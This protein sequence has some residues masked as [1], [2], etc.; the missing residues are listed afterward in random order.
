MNSSTPDLY[1]TVDSE[2]S[3]DVDDAFCVGSLPGGSFHVSVAIANPCE[4]VSIGSDTDINARKLGA[5]I[6]LRD[7]PAHRMIHASIS[8]DRA[9]LVQG[10]SRA[11]LIFDMTLDADLEVQQA[12]VRSDQINV[13]YRLSYQDIPL[14][15]SEERRVGKECVSTCRSRWSPYH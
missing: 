8:E 5:T 11:V 6:Y 15:R 13:A 1:I 10:M 3:R 4:L 9:S 2:T 7:H 12:V 14:V